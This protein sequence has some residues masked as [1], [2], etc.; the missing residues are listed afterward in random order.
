MQPTRLAH[1][2]VTFRTKRTLML[3]LDRLATTGGNAA[4]SS[5]LS[6]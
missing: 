6:T 2:Y 1:G 3:D 5:T 4:M